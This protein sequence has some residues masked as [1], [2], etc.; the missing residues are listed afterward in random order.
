MPWIDPQPFTVSDLVDGDLKSSTVVAE[1][2]YLPAS[3]TPVNCPYSRLTTQASTLAQ[4]ARQARLNNITGVD[5]QARAGSVF[6]LL[7][8]VTDAAGNTATRTRNVTI[9]DT[10]KPALNTSLAIHYLEFRSSDV[11]Q[12]LVTAVDQLEGDITNNVCFQ[13]YQTMPIFNTT[14]PVAE[15]GQLLPIVSIDWSNLSSPSTE[16]LNVTDGTTIIA[17]TPVGTKY[18]ID[19]TVTDE[20]GWE[21]SA[22]VVVMVVDTTP[23]TITLAGAPIVRVPFGTRYNEPGFTT[24]DISDSNITPYTIVN[25]T[26]IVAANLEVPGAYTLTYTAR[27]RYN[28]TANTTRRVQVDPFSTPDDMYVFRLEYT[29]SPSTAP[30][31][32]A[33]ETSLRSS[34]G[35]DFLFVLSRY[36]PA[37][38]PD[39][40]NVLPNTRVQL[41]TAAPI[42]RNT[43]TQPSR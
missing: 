5:P 1:V 25:G 28:N 14:R 10:L 3:V 15:A 35:Y 19:Y 18:L 13:V 43:S 24:S 33:F 4:T 34:T 9:V 21:D 30:S 23:P 26:D 8:E 6:D 2:A 38:L 20:A 31:A 16:P 29:A 39:R 11:Y 32:A 17:T 37:E 42:V 41:S 27:D 22:R 7:Y 12:H 40:F 36:D